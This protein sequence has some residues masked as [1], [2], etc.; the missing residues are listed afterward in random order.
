MGSLP[1]KIVQVQIERVENHTPLY[2]RHGQLFV[3][4][5]D[6]SA[7]LTHVLTAVCEEFSNNNATTTAD[8]LEVRDSSG[9]QGEENTFMLTIFLFPLFTYI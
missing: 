2:T 8:G 4:I 6:S 9:T 7:N 1:I 5:T 3:N